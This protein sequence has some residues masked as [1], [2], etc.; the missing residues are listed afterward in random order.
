ME[1]GACACCTTIQPLDRPS[2]DVLAFVAR[3]LES[4][5]ILL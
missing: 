4:G 2:L 3:R 5:P 1:R